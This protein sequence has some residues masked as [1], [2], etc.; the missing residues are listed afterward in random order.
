M[1]RS[2]IVGVVA[3]ALA[4]GC[5]KK[6]KPASFE[7]TA[8]ASRS[9]AATAPSPPTEAPR[10]PRN[11]N[12]QSGAGVVQN[13]RK[14]GMRTATLNDL[15]QL[16]QFMTL[17]L[18]E[19]GKVPDPKAVREYIKRDAPKLVTLIDDGAIV[20]T[21]TK[22]RAGLWAYEVDADRAGGVGLVGGTPQRMQADD[23]KRMLGK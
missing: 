2:L 7:D 23:V 13:V 3:A 18:N 8:P 9:A 21:G 14:A 16:G 11:T 12:Y 6:P 15:Q 1:T 17:M 19:D 20:M 10:N 5:D 22:D 4:A